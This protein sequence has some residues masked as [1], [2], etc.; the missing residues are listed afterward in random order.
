VNFKTLPV[1]PTKD[2]AMDFEIVSTEDC[3]AVPNDLSGASRTEMYVKLE[4]DL[5]EQIKMCQANRIYFKSTGDVPST[6]KFH[7]MEEHTKK[8][9]DSLRN[10]FKR[11]DS[12]P[13]FHYEVRS[14]SKVVLCP[15]LTDNELEFM[16]VQGIN[17]NVAK[18]AHTYCRLEFPYPKETPFKDKSVVVKETNANITEYN[19]SVK[20]PLNIKDKTC[21]RV[22]K[23]QSAKVE[24]W[25]K[26]GFL[27]SDTCLGSVQVKLQPLESQCVLHDTFAL[28]DGRKAVGGQLEIKIRIRNPMVTKQIEKVEEKWLVISF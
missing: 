11:G 13:K 12:V 7:Q 5:L 19:H 21:Q 27:R 4:K 14:F 28:M 10:S 25:N 1:L 15:E 23:R 18:D 17:L 3:G 6:N 2:V 9:L 8:D 20:V 22:F 26:V 24:V 16:V